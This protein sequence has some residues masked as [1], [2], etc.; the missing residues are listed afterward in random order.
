[1]PQSP[2]CRW[3]N[4]MRGERSLLFWQ[5]HLGFA[6]NHQIAW[7]HT[8]PKS[9]MSPEKGTILEGDYILSS[10]HQF[11]KAILVSGRVIL[12][13]FGSSLQHIPSRQPNSLAHQGRPQ[14]HLAKKSSINVY[15]NILSL[16][17]VISHFVRHAELA[18]PTPL[19]PSLFLLL[20]PH[21]DVDQL[22][23]LEL[24]RGASF[25]RTRRPHP[26]GGVGVWGNGNQFKY[27]KFWEGLT[28]K[29]RKLFFCYE[30]N[31]IHRKSFE[32]L[33]SKGATNYTQVQNPLYQYITSQHTGQTARHNLP[34][35]AP[36]AQ[37]YILILLPSLNRHPSIPN[38]SSTSININKHLYT[39]Q[40]FSNNGTSNIAPQPTY[41]EEAIFPSLLID[42]LISLYATIY[43]HI[44]TH[45]YTIHTMY[46][47]IYTYA[48]GEGKTIDTG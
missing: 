42:P 13:C 48:W 19:A 40:V 28:S 46:I 20:G 33:S 36:T 31:Y 38:L 17:K 22:S 5:Y 18:C 7:V 45:V 32:S 15:P 2:I 35:T 25:L 9:N 8:P 29:R 3:E 26:T 27:S 37:P 14:S 1:M 39:Q 34:C 43:I 44:Y 21:P 30:T 4:L 10:N 6:S 41:L 47:Y 23:R 12:F 24:P 16:G 11:S